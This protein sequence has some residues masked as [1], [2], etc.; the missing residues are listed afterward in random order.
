MRRGIRL[1][2]SYVAALMVCACATYKPPT[3]GATARM[4]F[5]GDHYYAY[6][7]EGNSCSTRQMVGKEMWPSTYVKAGQRIR[8][9]QGIDTSGL[10][11]AFK[12]G[13]ALSFEPQA[14]TTYVSEYKREGTRCKIGLFRL[15]AK[16][17]L[18]KE[19]SMRM[20]SPRACF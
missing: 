15:S 4:K 5:T 19:P 6:V 13:F 10:A 16:G 2:L 3:A 1:A 7:D 8:I 11:Y 18:T 14:E 9:E 12:C 17:E 20:E